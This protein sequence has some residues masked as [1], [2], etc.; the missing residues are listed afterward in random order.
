MQTQL[1]MVTL[2]CFMFG[3]LGFLNYLAVY[4]IKVYHFDKLTNTLFLTLFAVWFAITMIFI[5]PRISKHQ[6]LELICFI[7]MIMQLI[8]IF[9]MLI[10]HSAWVGW[11][12]LPF[13]AIGVS[14]AYVLLVTILSNRADESQQGRIMGV[15]AS[16]MSLVW[17]IAPTISGLLQTVNYNRLKA[18][19]SIYAWKADYHAKASII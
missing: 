19:A 15:T 6:R 8:P 11:L 2:T 3:Y 5:V 16:M 14:A 9:F 10:W 4:A 1:I 13:I 18:V 17:T 12:A 7:A